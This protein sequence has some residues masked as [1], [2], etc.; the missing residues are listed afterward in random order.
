MTKLNADFF[1]DP[2]SIVCNSIVSEVK[3][4]FFNVSC[5]YD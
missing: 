1:C 3:M 4:N 2:V 5:L